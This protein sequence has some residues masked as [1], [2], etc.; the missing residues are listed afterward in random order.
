MTPVLRLP[1]ST[2]AWVIAV[3]SR[4]GVWGL[5]AALLPVFSEVLGGP[6]WLTG[7]T[8]LVPTGFGTSGVGIVVACGLVLRS[9]PPGVSALKVASIA[10][11][12]MGLI[13]ACWPVVVAAPLGRVADFV[14]ASGSLVVV[15]GVLVVVALLIGFLGG[16]SA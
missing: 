7:S 1:S 4:L 8:W 16:R 13:F 6:R 10:G 5:V 11:I 9:L 15:L 14:D 12:P 3:A 2:R